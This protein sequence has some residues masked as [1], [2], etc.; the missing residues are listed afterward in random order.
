[1]PLLLPESV[2]PSRPPPLL[3]PESLP[4]SRPPPPL[5]LL[6][7]PLPPELLDPELELL[8]PAPLLDPEPLPLPDPELLLPDSEP[9]LDPEPM[10][11][12]LPLLPELALPS[13]E[14]PF[15][16]DE[17]PPQSVSPRDRT[18][19]SGASRKTQSRFRLFMGT[20]KFLRKW[21]RLIDSRDSGATSGPVAALPMAP[22]RRPS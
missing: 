13:G 8:L 12:E 9:L 17:S 6:L 16:F 2:P 20:P 5:L 22:V 15:T 18:V 3:L 14:G 11:P 19:A 4:P 1:L 7:E 10:P 21:P